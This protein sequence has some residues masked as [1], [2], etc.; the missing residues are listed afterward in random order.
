MVGHDSELIACSTLIPIPKIFAFS[1]GID[2]VLG[3]PFTLMSR[4]KGVQLFTLWFNKEWFKDE[5][6]CTFF[7]SLAENMSQL[8]N[9]TFPKIGS[10]ELLD[11]GI[12]S[13]GPILPSWEEG[14][15]TG[16]F[17]FRSCF[18]QHHNC[19][20]IAQRTAC[21]PSRGY[22][23]QLALLRMFALSLLYHCLDDPPFVLSE[24]MPDLTI[25]IS[26]PPKMEE[27]AVDWDG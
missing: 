21:V 6:R 9:I 16:S 1:L 7:Q 12:L 24:S 15:T 25:R 2:N 27:L 18:S 20:T 19:P 14:I 26:L 4:A 11:D 10:P 13:V 5:H 17:C 22:Q 3:H 8:K 23:I